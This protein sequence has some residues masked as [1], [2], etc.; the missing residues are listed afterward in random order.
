MTYQLLTGTLPFTGTMQQVM[1]QHFSTPP[2]PVL[3]TYAI[4]QVN[5]SL[6][7]QLPCHVASDS[8]WK[9]R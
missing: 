2:T 7:L 6:P 1:F 8:H 3:A 5:M 4:Q 9:L